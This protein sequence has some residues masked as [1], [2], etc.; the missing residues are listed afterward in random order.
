MRR[1]AT[2][3][4]PSAVCRYAT[5]VPWESVNWLGAQLSGEQAAAR[6]APGSSSSATAARTSSRR[7]IPALRIMDPLRSTRRMDLMR[8]AR[9]RVE[10]W[11]SAPGSGVPSG[12]RS[13]T[14]NGSFAST[15]RAPFEPL[16]SSLAT[17]PLPR[18]SPRRR[19]S[20]PFAT[21]TASTG[22]A[23]SVP[24]CTGS[25]STARSTGPAPA[26]C[27]P[28]WSSATHFAAPPHPEPKRRCRSPRIAD[29]PPEHR[30]VVVLRY[31]LEYTP[32]RSPSCSTFR[33]VPSTRG[34]AAASI[35]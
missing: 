34:S 7:F 22:A 8:N 20:P 26:G 9:R 2:E 24:G 29:L 35:G 16:G 27:A 30:A 11:R 25:W 6:A 17:P 13:T 10:G 18:T 12:A 15:G 21:S 28:R 4:G 23:R 3:T 14:S 32:G 1:S 33:A 5:S 31:L 19:S